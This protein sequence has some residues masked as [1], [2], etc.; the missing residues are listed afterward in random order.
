[1]AEDLPRR[2]AAILS[3]DVV[4][5]SR[6]MEVDEDGTIAALRA[7]RAEVFDPRIAECGG[8]I[9]NTAGDSLLVEFPSAVAAVRCAIE[10]QRA[11]GERASDLAEDRRLLF[12]IGINVGDVVAHGDDL[13][14]DGVNIAA[15]LQAL[16]SPGAIL[17]SGSVHDHISGKLAV[18][19]RERGLV[20]LKNIAREVPAFEIADPSGS[21]ATRPTQAA[22]ADRPGD[23]IDFS[24]FDRASIVVLP[25]RDLGGSDRDC[26]GEGL[27]LSLHSVL[28]KLPGLFLL[29]TA[30]VDQ[31]RGRD[32]SAVEVGREIKVGYVVG[33]AVQRAGN[34]VRILVDL[35]DVAAGEVIWADRLDR[36]LE[37][38]F[39]FQDE[40]SREIVNAIGLEMR[41][42]DLRRAMFSGA[43]SPEGVAHLHRSVSHLYRGTR[44]DTTIARDW[45]QMLLAAE[46]ENPWATGLIA[47]TYWREAKFGWT[48]D[49][50]ECVDLA[51][52]FAERAIAKGDPEGVGHTVLSYARLC[53]R[54]FDEALAASVEA[55]SRRPSCPVSNGMLAEVMRFY[56]HPDQ[57]VQRMRDAMRLARNFPP[58][59]ASSLAA[60]LRDCG[61][62]DASMEAANQ[63][64]RLFPGDIDSQVTLCSAHVAAGSLDK[65]KQLARQIRD[66]EPDFSVSGYIAGQPYRESGT[67]RRI[68]ENLASAGLPE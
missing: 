14:G 13:L 35:T 2:L 42:G 25:F 66:A 29:H 33:G 34:R 15:R 46:P 55:R 9:A 16:C 47:L 8:R 64:T 10:I 65:A 51:I 31:Y 26:L 40:V 27:R 39:D 44:E 56:G 38:I 49:P 1:M 6:L 45:A 28:I 41:G 7:L 36:T 48:D 53:Q 60:A 61:D 23:A 54:R 11:I 68:A 5:Y 58:W 32:V 43:S 4:G 67:L 22:H 17:I 50:V 52:S 62:F 30:S 63:A 20:R 18:D 3:A 12:R 24:R 37:D 59:M 57:A 21:G 19:I